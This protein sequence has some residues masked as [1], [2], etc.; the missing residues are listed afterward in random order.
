MY[1]Q[2]ESNIVD[3]INR[4]VTAGQRRPGGGP[5]SL[6]LNVAETTGDCNTT[7]QVGNANVSKTEGNDNETNQ[8]GEGNKSNTDGTKNVITQISV[9]PEDALKLAEKFLLRNRS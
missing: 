6:G 8:F 9:G 7:I 1:Q 5:D 2:V 4:A 3:M